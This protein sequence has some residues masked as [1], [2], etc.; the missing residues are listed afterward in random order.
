V[1]YNF[2]LLALICITCVGAGA[3]DYSTQYFQLSPVMDVSATDIRQPVP[4]F[5]FYDV[6]EKKPHQIMDFK[7]KT[8]IIGFWSSWCRPCRREFR[9]LSDMAQT[10]PDKMVLVMMSED[11]DE[12]HAMDLSRSFPRLHN[13]YVTWDQRRVMQNFFQVFRYPGSIIIAPGGVAQRKIIGGISHDDEREIA[14]ALH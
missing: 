1:R 9:V 8:V 6:Q 12:D 3:F 4:N 10:H 7:N 13:V 14:A 2:L 11:N 5:T